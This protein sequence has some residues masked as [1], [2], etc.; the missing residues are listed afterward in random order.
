[1][2]RATAAS[3]A[4]FLDFDGE[5]G[6]DFVAS[7]SRDR[8][9]NVT[10]EDDLRRDPTLLQRPLN[11]NQRAARE[12]TFAAIVQNRGFR[13]M[14]RETVLR[15]A[16]T[17]ENDA[18]NDDGD[19]DG[20]DD[21]GGGSDAVRVVDDG[22]A[23][24]PKKPSLAEWLMPGDTID[25]IDTIE[26]RARGDDG[27]DDGDDEDDGIALSADAQAD[28]AGVD[29]ADVDSARRST[30]I[31]KIEGRGDGGDESDSDG[32]D[33]NVLYTFSAQTA[34]APARNAIATGKRVRV[35][36]EVAPAAETACNASSVLD[37]ECVCERERADAHAHA[38]A[39]AHAYLCAARAMVRAAPPGSRVDE[40]E[41]ALSTRVHGARTSGTA[42][43]AD[44]ARAGAVYVERGFS[45]GHVAP[46][47]YYLYHVQDALHVVA[48]VERTHSAH[49]NADFEARARPLDPRESIIWLSYFYFCAL[50][51]ERRAATHKRKPEGR[52]GDNGDNGDDG[53]AQ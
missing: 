19:G 30:V 44:L 28:A 37:V 26:P 35:P 52:D 2:R 17:V 47:H 5:W 12:S 48:Y 39:H 50:P 1:M 53:D 38:H 25:A 33:D 32:D 41:A 27:D 22:E 49:T 40:V 9:D 24:P 6:I 45:F 46:S 51:L 15:I 7:L 20:G 21:R 8:L 23:L 10:L 11:N 13:N 43:C 42:L 31:A 36:W 16:R 18:G 14:P 3:T 34:G 29:V 4:A